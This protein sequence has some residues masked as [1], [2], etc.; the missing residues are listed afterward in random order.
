M[1]YHRIGDGGTKVW[2]KKA[3]GILFTDGKSVLLLKRAGEGDN[4]G[5]WALPG[6]KGRDGETEIH[7][8]CREAREETGLASIPGHRI[9]SMSTK[10]GQQKFTTYIYRVNEPFEVTLSKEHSESKWVPF[11]EV[12]RMELHPKFR[13]AFPEYLRMIRKKITSF[14]EWSQ[15]TDIIKKGRG[16]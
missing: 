4:I 11:D 2:G 8:A 3:A 13:D 9:D 7:T 12:L 15:L 5:K 1:G 10:N 14:S 6:G 16:S